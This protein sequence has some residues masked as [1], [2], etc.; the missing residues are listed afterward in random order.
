MLPDP[1]TFLQCGF[2]NYQDD[3]TLDAVLDDKSLLPH[4]LRPING[5][6][7]LEKEDT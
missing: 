2:N 3:G 4:M 7:P 5:Q 6:E 1:D